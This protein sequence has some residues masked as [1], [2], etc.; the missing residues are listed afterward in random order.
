MGALGRG[1]GSDMYV[2]PLI[3]MVLLALVAVAWSPIFALVI[4][5]LFALVFAAFLGLRPR[6]DQQAAQP[7]LPGPR[8][9]TKAGD[10]E[11]TG[12]W[13]ERRPE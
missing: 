12:L 2:I 7:D 10:D 3:V 4:F 1:T 8:Q 9:T 11:H 6:A 5:V 13:G